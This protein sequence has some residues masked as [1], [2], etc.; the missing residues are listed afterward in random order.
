MPTYVYRCDQCRHEFEAL[1]SIREAP[2][3]ICPKC[4]GP[5]RRLIGTGVGFIFKGSGFYATDYKKKP[6]ESGTGSA[7][8]SG[9]KGKK[10]KG[11]G[12]AKSD[13]PGKTNTK[14]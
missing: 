13:E 12:A 9:D 2:R 4:N 10:G 1:Q 7:A 5:V 11:E 3:T 6:A 14:T 8:P